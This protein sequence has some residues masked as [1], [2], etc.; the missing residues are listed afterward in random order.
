M[1]VIGPVRTFHE[2]GC[3]DQHSLLPP[4]SPGSGGAPARR[5]KAL[6][7]I[8]DEARAATLNARE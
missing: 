6:I 7:W 3:F 1:L 4:S 5:E 8:I 2:R